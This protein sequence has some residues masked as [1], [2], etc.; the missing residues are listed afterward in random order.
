MIILNP[1]LNQ[2]SMAVLPADPANTIF[3]DATILFNEFLTK[4]Q[5]S[6]NMVLKLADVRKE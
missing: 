3:E 4:V 1:L 5:C 6:C 2:Y